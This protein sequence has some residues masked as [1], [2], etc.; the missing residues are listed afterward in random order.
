MYVD[1]IKQQAKSLAL[2]ALHA[3]GALE[4]RLLRK[5]AGGALILAYHRVAPKTTIGREVLMPGMYV[6]TETLST[7]LHWL[8][9]HYR[10][11]TVSELLDLLDGNDRNDLPLCAITFDDG[12]QDNLLYALPIL[13]YW[14]VRA[15][16]F[17]I[18]SR[19][20]AAEP[21]GWDMCFE[22]AA[23][24][25]RPTGPVTGHAD[26]D[27]LFGRASQDRLAKARAILKRLRELPAQEYAAVCQGLRSYY[28]ANLDAERINQ[29]YRMLSWADMRV[30]QAAGTEFGYHTASHY[31]LTKV[32]EPDLT[33][34]LTIP[35]EAR[36][37]GI[38]IR[39]IL[40]YPDGRHDDRVVLAARELGYRAAVGLTPGL[41]RRSTNR[42]ALH[43]FNVHEGGASSI[44]RFLWTLASPRATGAEHPPV[45]SAT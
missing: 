35:A 9:A 41:N 13:R 33:A 11:V 32:R 5:S 40:C 19:I 2:T 29:R 22:I 39:P 42:Y 6:S 45:L 34:E 30:M 26:L 24:V 4:R 15:T 20:G 43:R 17:P 18:G 31:M 25:E 21:T 36:A 37:N 10:M 1:A 27:G 14:Q 16:V 12:W 23:H 38:D 7:H 44:P 8:S 28:Y 3:S